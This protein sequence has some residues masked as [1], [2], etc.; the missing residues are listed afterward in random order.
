MF[1]K[2]LEFDKMNP[3][4]EIFITES[5]FHHLTNRTTVYYFFDIIDYKEHYFE[6]NN[7]QYHFYSI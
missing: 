1:A 2:D 6:H 5:H 4:I 7:M 3:P